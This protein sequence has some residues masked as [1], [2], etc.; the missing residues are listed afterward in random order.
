MFLIFTN[1]YNVTLQNH[2]KLRCTIN[3]LTNSSLAYWLKLMTG[4]VGQPAGEQLTTL[5]ES[6]AAHGGLDLGTNLGIWKLS[7]YRS[8]YRWRE[9]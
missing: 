3:Q 2:L 8:T 5:P 1:I 9:T 6:F 4:G 7:K